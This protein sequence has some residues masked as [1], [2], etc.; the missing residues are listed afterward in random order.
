MQINRPITLIAQI[1]PLSTTL[2]QPL[3]GP[4]NLAAFTYLNAGYHDGSTL[5]AFCNAFTVEV[6]RMP[7]TATL[8]D[9][10]WKAFSA[11]SVPGPYLSSTASRGLAPSMLRAFWAHAID[12]VV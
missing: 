9:L 3:F 6:S 12:P 2:C 11:T 4:A 5:S 7:V 8:G 10:V 1:L